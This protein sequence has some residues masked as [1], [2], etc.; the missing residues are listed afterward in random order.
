MSFDDG[1]HYSPSPLSRPKSSQ[2]P[3]GCPVCH[4]DFE[5][6]KR[7]RIKMDDQDYLVL[8]R[9]LN[10]LHTSCHSCLEES[11]QRTPGII[12]C[13]ICRH[14]QKTK[15]VKYLPYD[16]IVLS[17]IVRM[18]GAS[19]MAFCCRCHDE[20]P[21]FSWCFTCHS[22]LC[23]FHH[24]DHRLSINTSTHQVNTFQEI[25]DENYGIDPRLPPI[26]CPEALGHDCTLLCRTCG[27]MISVQAMVE[28]HKGHN[29][30]D[31]NSIFT[32]CT[33]ILG[34]RAKTVQDKLGELMRN[35]ED[36]KNALM[37]LEE[38]A[39]ASMNELK[40][41]FGALHK[42]LSDREEQLSSKLHKIVDG[43]RK[44]LSEQLDVL[45]DSLDNCRNANFK[46]ESILVLYEGDRK[47]HN[48]S[49]GKEV[50]DSGSKSITNDRVKSPK[51]GEPTNWSDSYLISS[52]KIIAD[53]CDICAS[54]A[55]ALPSEPVTDSF[56][57]F[58]SN[59]E[60]SDCIVSG[61]KKIGAVLA[62]KDD[63]R[64]ENIVCSNSNEKN[65]KISDSDIKGARKT[66]D[67]KFVVDNCGTPSGEMSLTSDRSKKG[68]SINYESN[69]NN[70][71]GGSSRISIEIYSEP[72]SKA[73]TI[74]N[75][76]KSIAA[77][78]NEEKNGDILKT[79]SIEGRVVIGKIILDTEIDGLFFPRHEII[80][81]IESGHTG[82]VPVLCLKSEVSSSLHK[83]EIGLLSTK[84]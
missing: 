11:V 48:P 72:R 57:E 31:A 83:K 53:R 32:L 73:K 38:E 46:A 41:H 30:V 29:V 39:E 40:D 70:N 18:N 75:D 64:F 47:D 14:K 52:T 68:G 44:V 63:V 9:V 19:A 74:N 23:E 6:P 84:I 28:N 51:L 59:N 69:N 61:I 42:A 45:S 43:K 16:V 12:T 56:V 7:Y 5:M 37:N 81:S 20:S 2:Q 1:H 24:Q 58:I 78:D 27:Y 10:C 49:S 82:Q 25:A 50:M 65:I 35:F 17:E 77:A 66:C 71:V 22:P 34:S 15:G 36:T 4:R 79:S 3:M 54:D 55:N 26:A 76:D 62:T 60:E 67:I 80:N 8:P 33:E 13:P 21:S